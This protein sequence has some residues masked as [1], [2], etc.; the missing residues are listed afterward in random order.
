MSAIAE[1]PA[2]AQTGSAFPS[3]SGEIKASSLMAPAAA[4]PNVSAD[5]IGNAFEKRMP[6]VVRAPI[7]TAEGAPKVVDD[8][9]K[10]SEKL[11]ENLRGLAKDPNAPEEATKTPKTPKTE[12]D[13]EPADEL[14]GETEKKNPGTSEVEAEKTPEVIDKKKVNPW[15]VI[16]EHK[17]A[18]SQLEAEVA[19]LKKLVA[20]PETRKAEVERLS[21]IEKRNQEL[22]ETIKFV[23][24]SKSKE[25]T[26]KYQ[27]PYEAAWTRAMSELK[28]LT[29]E[30]TAT[31]ETRSMAPADL[32][33]LV[34]LPLLKAREKA[35][36]LYG[37]AANEV[38]AYRKEI[39]GLYEQQSQA[40]DQA[41][42]SGVEKHQQD[43]AQHAQKMQA[44]QAETSK[45]W[46]AVNKA[47]LENETTG[48]YFRPVEGNDEINGR[49]EKGYKF[50][51]ETMAMNP[52]NPSLTPEQR[53]DA[54]KR[55][56]SLRHRAAAFGRM[57][58]EV[59]TL[60]KQYAEVRKKLTQFEGSVP[61]F[62]GDSKQGAEILA[63]GGKMSGLMQRLQ[64][65]AR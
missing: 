28:E 21:A 3:S 35:D 6:P 59:E 58:H 41:R 18:R 32:L 60:R 24:Y 29:V 27:K 30:D 25:F 52:L 13:D 17:K 31:G 43:T 36:E 10:P 34:N 39:R 40:L 57:R 16:D 56:A 8:G 11:F 12:A 1:A 64:Q 55:H 4:K 26:E 50:V 20:N 54:I 46:E 47:I 63:N 33:D 5:K 51:D 61:N 9:K 49:L 37:A 48:P 62:G 45:H 42:K 53:Q 22:E 15:K 23:D 65:K 19:D 2:P 38:M 44:L 7:P 14:L